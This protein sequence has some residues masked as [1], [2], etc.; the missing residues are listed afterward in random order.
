MAG[1]SPGQIVFDFDALEGNHVAV[2]AVP[3][4]A[5]VRVWQITSGAPAGHRGTPPLE[6]A[7]RNFTAHVLV[8]LPFDGVSD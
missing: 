4:A 6:R 1:V 2:A 3:R 7:T 5:R 8:A